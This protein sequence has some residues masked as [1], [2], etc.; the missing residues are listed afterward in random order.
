MRAAHTCWLRRTAGRIAA[1]LVAAQVT[2]NRISKRVRLQ[3]RYG[4]ARSD[5]LALV[6]T[7]V[8]S[9]IL[10]LSTVHVLLSLQTLFD[11][12]HAPNLHTSGVVQTLPSSHPVPSLTAAL[13]HT[14]VATLQL[15][16]VH[17]LLSLQFLAVLAHDPVLHPSGDVHALPS[18]HGA[19]SAKPM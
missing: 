11:D 2:I 9:T 19:P 15:S 14:P 4:G 3:L 18:S 7:Q 5:T 10:Q 12:V 8:P 17:P 13:T 16:A 6:K 1:V